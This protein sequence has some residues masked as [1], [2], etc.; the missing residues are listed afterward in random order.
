MNVHTNERGSALLISLCLLAMLTLIG[1][2]AIQNSNTDVDLAFNRSHSDKA[3]YVA[4]A[5]AKRAFVELNQD[6]LWRTGYDTVAF[7]GGTYDVTLRDSSTDAALIDTVVIRSIGVLDQ[8]VS[9]LELTTVP[10]DANRLFPH[11]MFAK[12]GIVI[13]RDACTD[14]YNSD[15]GSYADTR[16]DSLGSV[17]S[18]GTILTS[19][20][21]TFG[22]DVSVA[23]PGGLTF[24]VNN[25]VNGDTTST[26]DS[27]DVDIIPDTE[28][29]WALANNTAPGGLSGSNYNFDSGTK[30]LVAGSYA[31]ITLTSGV[32]FF[33]S[34]SLGQGS[35]VSL[36]P[37]A[38]VTIYV[39]G[40]IVLKQASS[41]NSSGRPIDLLIY[42]KGS[43][44]QFDQGNTF[45]GAFYG[46]DA[47]IQYDQTTQ[48][49]GALLGN[50]IKLDK[51]ACF[52]FDRD[53]LNLT[54]GTTGDYRVVAWLEL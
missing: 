34:I 3:F 8:A 20:D 44:L 39:T 50:T 43:R 27:V 18:N 7:S 14:S 21:V 36:A 38:T 37:G 1:I 53:L 4:E 12:S 48:V 9:I 2:M 51:A 11:A 15:S 22:G 40:D 28:Y 23:T 6:N 35:T 41:I 24:G 47:H 5:G 10:G 49:F 46:P 13:D 30:A 31:N 33:S 42:S 25:V 45:N 17:G 26:A 29:D 52:H 54:R 16:L 32:Y 19:K